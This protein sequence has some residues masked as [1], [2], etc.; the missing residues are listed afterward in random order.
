MT[1]LGCR[2]LTNVE[3]ID[4]DLGG[5]E[6]EFY[7][8][9]PPIIIVTNVVSPLKTSFRGNFPKLMERR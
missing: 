2:S 9:L 4:L 3:T 1:S 7:E 5:L 6:I 8:P